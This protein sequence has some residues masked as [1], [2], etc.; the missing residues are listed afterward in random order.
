MAHV[1]V[2]VKLELLRWARDRARVI[3]VE[4]ESKFPKLEQ[5][6]KGDPYPM[7]K[8]LEAYA[9]ATHAPIGYLFPPSPD[10]AWKT[11]RS[12]DLTATDDKMLPSPAQQ[13]MSKRAGPTVVEGKASRAVYV[14]KPEAVAALIDE[15]AKAAK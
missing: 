6:E 9:K 1:R 11:K 5:W 8:Q 10:P 13:F 15:A 4:L 12:W 2:K 7:L 3:T 14:S